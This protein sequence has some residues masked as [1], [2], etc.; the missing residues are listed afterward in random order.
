[1]QTPSREPALKSNNLRFK[2]KAIKFLKNLKKSFDFKN[3]A[4]KIINVKNDVLITSE[5]ININVILIIINKQIDAPTLSEITK[6]TIILETSITIYKDSLNNF[7][8]KNFIFT[9]NDIINV[10]KNVKIFCISA[11][12]IFNKASLLNVTQIFRD[13]IKIR[14]I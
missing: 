14:I 9:F 12:K 13:L 5:S 2:S 7:H 6:N 1:M 11:Y 4:K 10:S 3:F 8:S